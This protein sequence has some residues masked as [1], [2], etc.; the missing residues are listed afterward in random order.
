MG[1]GEQSRLEL[2]WPHRGKPWRPKA[3]GWGGSACGKGLIKSAWRGVWEG[4][5]C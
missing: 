5:L 4:E 2:S 1:G 3:A